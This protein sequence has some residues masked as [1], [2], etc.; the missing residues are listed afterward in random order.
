MSNDSGIRRKHKQRTAPHKKHTVYP[1]MTLSSEVRVE[2]GSIKPLHVKSQSS[3]QSS[4]KPVERTEPEWVEYDR[5]ARAL[6]SF[7][8][9]SAA[10]QRNLER[11]YTLAYRGLVRASLAPK[12]RRK[13]IK[14]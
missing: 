12:L 2:H 9:K 14:N 7:D 6:T 8:N 5:A 10:R 11:L 13:Y 4:K 1:G 3:T